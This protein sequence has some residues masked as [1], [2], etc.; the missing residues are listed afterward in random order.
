MNRA[1]VMCFL[2]LL[3]GF[4]DSA[5][6]DAIVPSDRVSVGVNVRTS[7]TSSS[8]ILKVLAPGEQLELVGSV[9][10]WYEVAL[11]DGRHGFVSKSW[12]RV[13]ASDPTSRTPTTAS[14]TIDV[15]DVGTGLAILVRGQDFALVYDGGSNDDLARGTANRLLAFLRSQHSDLTT[16]DHMILSHPHRDHVELLPDVV[17]AYQVRNFWDSGAINDI[18]GYRAFIQSIAD[19]P[20][21]VYHSALFD[22]GDHPVSFPAHNCYGQAL[23]AKSIALRYGSRI[24]HQPI[25]L[26]VNASMTFLYA[27][28]STHS[29][30]NQNSLVM[31]LDF[32]QTK[33]LFMG[34]AEAGGRAAP[35]TPPATHS[36]EGIL[37]DCCVADLHAQVLIVGHHGSKTSSRSVFLNAVGANSFVI[38]SGPTKYGSVT[39]PD[40]VIVQELQSRGNLFRT[41]L[42]D[43][44]CRQK[45]AKIG[46]DNDG[47]AGGCDNIRI[48]ISGTSP[49]TLDYFRPG[50]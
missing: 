42:N 24:D 6:S 3:G 49:L 33:V 19:E 13:I 23:A 7:A 43:Q 21:A 17:A 10:G 34:D 27:D 47:E 29:G 36:I 31:R 1:I 12:T 9:P 28:G 40:A 2:I 26:G 46:P 50:D 48:T 32:G 11:V 22:F 25:P 41:D 15:V 5:L 30:F 8:E 35:D 20:Q 4:R 39:L 16:I 44:T 37:L 38:S 45:T 18:C 14:L